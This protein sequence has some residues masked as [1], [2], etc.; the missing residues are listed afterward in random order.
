MSKKNCVYETQI[1]KVKRI[2]PANTALLCG[3]ALLTS[4]CIVNGSFMGKANLKINEIQ[5]DFVNNNQSYHE[6]IL[7]RDQKLEDK[8][9]TGD[10]TFDQYLKQKMKIPKMMILNLLLILWLKLNR[11]RNTK[12]L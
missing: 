7:E 1:K 8:Y 3:F 5:T 10:I 11:D 4:L 6:Y 9:T 2:K 12:K